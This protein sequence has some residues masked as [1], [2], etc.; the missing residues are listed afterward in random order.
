MAKLILPIHSNRRGQGIQARLT[1]CYA[2]ANPQGAK[3]PIGLLGCPG[4]TTL[5]TLPKVPY[6]GAETFDGTLYAV[7]G[8]TLYSITSAGATASIG[9][10]N[11]AGKVS[12][13]ENRD[14]LS[15]YTD[16]T[17]Y[18]YDGTTLAEIDD[19]DKEPATLVDV[20]E[21]FA[22][23][24]RTGTDQF[25]SS[26]L[27]NSAVFNGL[28]FDTAASEPDLL[29]S[30]I[31]DRQQLILFGVETSEKWWVFGGSGFPLMRIP[32]GVIPFGCIAAR[33]PTKF[34][35]RVGWV[36]ENVI[37]RVLS[38]SQ[39]LKISSHAIDSAFDKITDPANIFGFSY[40][41][42]GHT[43]YCLTTD[44]GT[45]V[46]DLSTSEW[47]E[48]KSLGLNRWRVEDVTR[49][50]D[51]QIAFDS[52]TGKF[53]VIDETLQTEF[54]DP[55]RMEWVYPTVYAEG[56]LASH[57]RL[58]IMP[59]VGEADATEAPIMG[60]SISDDGGKT[61]VELETK[62][63]GLTGEYEQ[64]LIWTKLGSSHN[65]VYR[66]WIS[67][68]IERGVFDTQLEVEGGRL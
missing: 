1:N 3:A 13:A 18:T 12:M 2:E 42:K 32:G 4:V 67:D 14:A 9:T 66:G 61:W 43:N 53:G 11:G 22:V 38:G 58:E 62:S 5:G 21:G 15:I 52:T 45:F 30:L 49:A 65:R 29:V 68:P 48:R 44:Q 28:D 31:V 36:D 20:I 56:R 6:R 64:S 39:G 50:Y 51:K 8:D 54:G 57:K 59:D 47:H 41:T 34:G 19:I 37:P 27:A 17:D 63:L 24:I 10:I 25:A 16:S 26:G 23:H 60:M 46:Y 55:I 33:S 35:A 7:A 40:S